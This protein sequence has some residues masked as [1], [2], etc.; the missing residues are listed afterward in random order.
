[1]IDLVLI[2]NTLEPFER[3]VRHLDP[4]LGFTLAS[5]IPDDWEPDL[6]QT[7]AFLNGQRIDARDVPLRDGDSVVLVGGPTDPVTIGLIVLSVASIAVGASM[8]PKQ[9]VQPPANSV[10]S[11]DGSNTYGYYGFQNNYNSEGSPLPVI[12]GLMRSAPPCINQVVSSANLNTEITLALRENLYSLFAVSQGPIYGFGEF[13]GPVRNAADQTALASNGSVG[14]RG[15]GLQINKLPGSNLICG[16]DWRTGEIDQE[17]LIGSQGYVDYTDTATAF[18]FDLTPLV[19]TPNIDRT[20]KPPGSFSPGSGQIT[21]AQ[22]QEYVSQNSE[23]LAD[24]AI[25][26]IAFNAGLGDSSAQNGSSEPVEKIIRVQYR[27]TDSSGVQSGN[28]LLLD[29]YVF[30]QAQQRSIVDIPVEFFDPDT[31]VAAAQQDH[32]NCL[33]TSN[34]DMANTN[35]TGVAAVRPGLVGAIAQWT[36]GGWVCCSDLDPSGDYGIN[37]WVFVHSTGSGA[38]PQNEQHNTNASGSN[39]ARAFHVRPNTVSTSGVNGIGVHIIRD[40]GNAYGAGADRVYVSLDWWGRHDPNPPFGQEY[41]VSYVMWDAGTT[42]IWGPDDWH[43]VAVQVVGTTYTCYL[44]GQPIAE[45]Q[46]ATMAKDSTLLTFRSAF[47]PEWGSTRMDVGSWLGDSNSANGRDTRLRVAE[48]FVAPVFL[49]PSFINLLGG[50]TVGIDNQGRKIY[51][52]REAQ[53]D[54]AV[55]SGAWTMERRLTPGAS[56]YYYENWIYGPG[57]STGSIALADGALLISNSGSTHTT[58]GCPVWTEEAADPL[59]SYWQTEVFVSSPQENGQIKNEATIN[60]VTFL[61]SQPYSYPEVA[62]ASVRI[63]ANAQVNNRLPEVTMLIKGRLIRTWD[64]TLTLGGTPE[65]QYE[66]TRNPAWIAADILCNDVYGLGGEIGEAGVDWPSF[67]DWANFCDETVVDAFGKG[68]VFGIEGEGF[69]VDGVSPIVKFYVGLAQNQDDETTALPESWLPPIINQSAA[70]P[71]AYLG[72]TDVD[73]DSALSSDW[74]TTSDVVGGLNDAS[75]GMPIF[76]VTVQEGTFHGWYRYAEIRVVWQRLDS[77]GNPVYPEG[78]PASFE[79]YADDLGVDRLMQISGM[80]DR[81]RCDITFDSGEETA[82]ESLLQVFSTGRAMPMKAGSKVFAVVDKPRPAVAAF[83]Q[84]NIVAKTVSIKYQGPLQVPNSL[85]GDILDSQANFEKRTV[86][87]DHPSIQDPSGFDTFRKD[88]IDLRG[89]T[90]RSQALRDLTYRLNGLYLRRRTVRFQVGPD[91]VHLIPGDRFKFSHDVPQYGYSGRLRADYNSTNVLPAGG[92]I[93][94][95]LN[96]NGG[97]AQGTSGYVVSL[98]TDARPTAFTGS[99]IQPTNYRCLP[100]ADLKTPAASQGLN[101][102]EL[103]PGSRLNGWAGQIVYHSPALYPPSPT[104]DPLDQ[105]IN[106]ATYKSAFSVYVK[107]PSLGAFKR[108]SVNTYVFRDSAGANVLHSNYTR[109][110]WASGVLSVDGSPNA[111]HTATV[112]SAGNG[113]YRVGVVYDANADAGASDGDYIQTRLYQWGQDATG[114]YA[115]DTFIS[116][117][118]GGRGRQFLK[119]ADPTD[120]EHAAGWTRVNNSAGSNAVANTSTAPPFYTATDG[121]Y[122]YVAKLLKS[123]TATGTTPP[124]IKQAISLPTGTG[125]SSWNGEFICVNGWLRIGAANTRNDTQLLLAVREGSA[126]DS[127][128]LLTGD[129]I[130]ATYQWNGSA[131]STTTPARVQ[132]SGS[133]TDQSAE[134]ND[135]LQDSSTTDSDWKRFNAAFKYTPT[136]GTLTDITVQL[137]VSSTG[138]TTDAREVYVWGLCAHGLGGSGSSITAATRENAFTHRGLDWWGAQYERDQSTVSTFSTGAGLKLDRDVTLEAG[139]EYEVLVRSSFAPDTGVAGDAIEVLSVDS[140]QVPGSGTS[141]ISANTNIDVSAPAKFAPREGDVYSF[142]KTGATSEDFI[143]QSITLDPETMSREIVGIEYNEAVFDDTAFGTQGTTTISDLPSADVE[144]DGF[145]R[146]GQAFSSGFSSGYALRAT[147]EPQRDNQGGAVFQ[148]SLNWRTPQSIRQPKQ[149]RFYLSDVWTV[150]TT[151]RRGQSPLRYLGS[152]EPGDSSVDFLRTD[153]VDGREYALYMQPVGWDDVASDP[154]GG[155]RTTAQARLSVDPG[156]I[157]PPALTSQTRGFLQVYRLDSQNGDR[158]ID[159]VE[160]RIGG[161]VFGAPAFLLDP[162]TRETHSDKTLV[163]QASTPTG[164][165]GATIYARSRTAGGRY[166]RALKLEGTEQLVDVTYTN[167]TSNENNWTAPGAL[168]TDLD[169][170]GNVLIWK[171][172][173][174]A[175]SAQYLPSQI[176]LGAAKRVL[177]NCFVEGT[178]IR[179]ETLADLTFQLGDATGRRWSLEGP[180][181]DKDGDNSTVLIEWR[182]TSAASF[183]TETYREFVPGEVY[184]RLINFRITFTR[185]TSSYGMRIERLVTQALELPAFEA[186][187][188]DGGTF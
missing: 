9:Q 174:S 123:G 75:S 158:Q 21:E 152:A 111:A 42:A 66:W 159:V 50:P 55:F 150:Q 109:F 62:L 171:S 137:Y 30:T 1:M 73:A 33:S 46:R 118:G 156:Q 14:V 52:I 51:G 49:G 116:V 130:T 124:I 60:S 80:E 186:D 183:T 74:V 43:H 56:V 84:G 176:D 141:T 170:D 67:L 101:G 100:A 108:F 86:L 28:W 72:I 70:D 154:R 6:E 102:W 119:W 98:T 97:P 138:S 13:E 93:Y 182:W 157:R 103:D 117:A 146:T 69:G 155:I 114:A 104:A 180:M 106:Q 187:D 131:W 41:Q 160:G 188:I 23:Q 32:A 57:G 82:W 19:G 61:D 135:V 172:S 132:A 24:S 107:E 63:Q 92:S 169:Q 121:T 177:V 147:I 39:F 115:N 148:V 151:P 71:R 139:E 142:G 16:I 110:V 136:S 128:G 59:K 44:D 34:R 134:I 5:A 179:P 53:L 149:F 45:F 77:S 8:L 165:T 88:R 4:G 112:T 68:D 178:Q 162:D 78:V 184:A 120:V 185:P 31:Y 91:A 168:S 125:I 40:A 47:Y 95:A 122:G 2:P 15:T 64:G 94:Y 18:E 127:N 48:L 58:G 143:V 181:D 133:V 96:V 25:V 26:Q 175:L 3:Q 129:G 166:G 7:V 164:R 140:T 76:G 12:Y 153:L 79:Y 90:R 81:C 65:F 89:V 126:V 35:A 173:S 17:P 163:G 20:S 36:I 87:V 85:E 161:W 29:E 27:R 54:G 37:N 11:P 144:S 145:A 167:S 99:T 10:T 113:W 38:L 83:G 22:D 105:I